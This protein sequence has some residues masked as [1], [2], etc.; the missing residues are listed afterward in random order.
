MLKLVTV[1]RSGVAQGDLG[2]FRS[3]FDG[4]LW[5]KQKAWLLQTVDQ[6]LWVL[7]DFV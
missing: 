1:N 4:W 3:L 2:G 6:Q 7:L 5:Q